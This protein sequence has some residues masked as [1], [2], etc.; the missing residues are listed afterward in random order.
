MN[1]NICFRTVSNAKLGKAEDTTVGGICETFDGF[2]YRA[3]AASGETAHVGSPAFDIMIPDIVAA[4]GTGVDAVSGATFSSNYYL[5]G[6]Q[7]ALD[8]YAAVSGN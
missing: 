4:N 1:K 2:K 6:I 8:V 5:E 7:S 3:G